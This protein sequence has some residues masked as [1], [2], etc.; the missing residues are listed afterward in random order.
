VVAKKQKK[1]IYYGK[2]FFY[3]KQLKRNWAFSN[4]VSFVKIHL[5]NYI[6]LM[7]FLENTEKDWRKVILK[8]IQCDLFT[9]FDTTKKEGLLLKI[10]HFVKNIYCFSITYIRI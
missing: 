9:I 4:L 10:N 1:Y 2:S 5:F 6:H 7:N 3:D 8:E